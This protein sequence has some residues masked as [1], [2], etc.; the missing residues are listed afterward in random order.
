MHIVRNVYHVTKSGHAL[1]V[2]LNP[3]PILFGLCGININGR[4]KADTKVFGE[5]TKEDETC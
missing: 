3:N 4:D 2:K 5:Y 1:S